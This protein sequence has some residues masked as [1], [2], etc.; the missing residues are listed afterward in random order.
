[1][2]WISS[3][4]EK[5]SRKYVCSK[6]NE[7]GRCKSPNFDQPSLNNAILKLIS[8]IAKNRIDR[9]DILP[10]ISTNSDSD[11]EMSTIRQLN[12]ELYDL[13]QAEQKLFD[14]Y[15][16]HSKISEIQYE[17]TIRRY[18]KRKKEII[19]L[20]EK[21]PMPK[22]KSFGDLGDIIDELAEALEV[23]NDEDKRRSV[24][25]LV[26]KIEP[27]EVTLVHFRWGEVKE[28]FP[29]SHFKYKSKLFLF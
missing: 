10:E 27:G 23:L 7:I 14:A 9:N 11:K 19:K 25:L 1:M 28:I 6:K 2:E 8:N 4:S 29:K 17:N 13:E 5:G 16:L 24:E 26:D 15:F 21:I 22:S 18:S 3:N 20:M 12:K